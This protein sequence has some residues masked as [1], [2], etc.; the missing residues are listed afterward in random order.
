MTL[1][2]LKLTRIPAWAPWVL[3]LALLVIAWTGWRRYARAHE[4]QAQAQDQVKRL[5]TQ[6]ADLQASFAAELRACSEQR[7][8]AAAAR[9]AERAADL[10]TLEE[11][12][13]VRPPAAPSES[14]AAVPDPAA[15]G[16]A[17]PGPAGVFLQA[18]RARWVD[19]HPGP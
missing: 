16:G 3:A 5:Q 4:A 2:A 18:L 9:A 12:L 8:Q 7:D 10:A 19:A 17:P 1:D 11:L 13:G 15:A 6:V 14:P